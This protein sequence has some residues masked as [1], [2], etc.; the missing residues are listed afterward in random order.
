MEF[1]FKTKLQSGET[2][3][4]REMNFKEYKNI[5]KVCIYD[6]L[7]IFKEYTDQVIEKLCL[8]LLPDNLNLVDK[9]LILAKIR[10]Y[11]VSSEKSL[12]SIVNDRETRFK[13]SIKSVTSEIEDIL[14]SVD[15]VIHIENYPIS[16]VNI[17]I[18]HTKNVADFI[19]SFESSDGERINKD[20]DIIFDLFPLDIKNRLQKHI[21]GIVDKIESKTLFSLVNK[22]GE[23]E[24]VKFILNE[25]YIYDL[26]KFFWKDDLMSIYKGIVDMKTV[27]NI[28]FKE[29]EYMTPAEKSL[30]INIYNKNKEE[31]MERELEK[32]S[33]SSP[34]NPR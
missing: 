15:R 19:T 27:M 10:S 7:N 4:F 23:S 31:E 26:I 1:Y 14:D 3:R 34:Y 2:L 9:F 29:L 21:D 8:D 17:T 28:S 32:N 5:Q 11:S 16:K 12:M 22:N 24:D 30:Y 6:D 25:N 13:V 20:T 33:K 18:P